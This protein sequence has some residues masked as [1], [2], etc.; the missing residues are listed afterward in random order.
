MTEIESSDVNIN[1]EIIKASPLGE[2]LTLEQ[3]EKLANIATASGLET[4]MFL[5]EEG[6]QD[7][8][9]HV[10]TKGMLEVVKPTGGGDWITLQVIREGQMI[11]EMGFVDGVEHS[12][13]IRALT[14]TEVFSLHRDEFETLVADDPQLV[15]Q[16]MRAIIRTI[17]SILRNMNLQ[18][19][20][21]TNYIT[22]QHGRY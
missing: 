18:Y 13:S 2:E 9:L 10:V 19:V 7:D 5:L 4:G 14:N 12:A 6:H 3:C 16:V 22:K 20:E 1:S 15:Y 11:G 8:T 17:H 21:M